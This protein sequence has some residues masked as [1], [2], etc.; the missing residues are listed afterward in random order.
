[1][2]WELVLQQ[3]VN[4]FACM[5]KMTILYNKK[6]QFINMKSVISQSKFAI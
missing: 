5:N 4:S 1:M 2:F 3:G 6:I